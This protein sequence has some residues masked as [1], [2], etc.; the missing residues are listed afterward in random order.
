MRFSFSGLSPGQIALLAASLSH[1]AVAFYLPGVAPTSY[2][3]GARVPLYVNALT[4]ALSPQDEQLHSVFAFGY[5]HPDLHFCRPEG[6]PQ[7][8]RESLGSIIFGDR[9]RTSPF[10]LLMAK[11]E[12]CKSLC[13][14]KKFDQRSAKFVNKSIW[15]N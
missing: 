9:I 6:G 12:T 13:D 4:P 8:V 11:N 7:D 1:S 3:L 14:E 5:Y 10:E 2:D 15:Q